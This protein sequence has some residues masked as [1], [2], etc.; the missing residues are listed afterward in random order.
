MISEEYKAYVKQLV[1]ITYQTE[2]VSNPNITM[3]ECLAKVLQE[4][5]DRKLHRETKEG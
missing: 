5:K 2:K 1:F 4:L 3:K